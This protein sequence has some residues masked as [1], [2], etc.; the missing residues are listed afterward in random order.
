MNGLLGTF[1]L[2]DF[3]V[4]FNVY[5]TNN[6]LADKA[7]MALDH[8]LPALNEFFDLCENLTDVT[9]AKI[10]QYGYINITSSGDYVRAKS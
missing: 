10:R 8:F 7:L 1:L 9:N 4:F 2:K 5:K 6:I 3:D